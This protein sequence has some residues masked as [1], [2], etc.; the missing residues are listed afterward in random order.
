M[1]YVTCTWTCQ[2]TSQQLECEE[3]QAFMNH[4]RDKVINKRRTTKGAQHNTKDRLISLY[5]LVKL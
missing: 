4:E 3:R 1:F 5:K 2:Y